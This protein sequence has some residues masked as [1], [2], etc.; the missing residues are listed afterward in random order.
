MAFTPAATTGAL[1]QNDTAMYLAALTGLTPGCLV[2]LDKEIVK[3][4]AVPTA[5][6]LPIPIMRG[7]EGTAAAPHP[8][9]TTARIGAVATPG[10]L[11]DWT[12][13][14]AG[15][16]SLAGIPS[17]PSRDVLGYAASG[18]ITLPKIGC[19]MVAVLNGTTI[20]A[21]TVASPTVGCDGSRL[22]IVG[23]GKAAHGITIATGLGGVG[24]TADVITF[25]AD[26]TMGIDLM[27]V[28]TAWVILSGV[29]GAATLAGAGIG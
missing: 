27:A 24:G 18:A 15:A 4:A 2:G 26:Q 12:Q 5:A 6:T 13:P 10:V 3:V 1:T 20:L 16:P 19:D 23:T 8:L 17:A 28:G 22:T 14:A 9:G 25:K 21:M 11:G 29:A 7:V